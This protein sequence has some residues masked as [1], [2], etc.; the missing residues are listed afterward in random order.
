[1]RPHS[2][3]PRRGGPTRASARKSRDSGVRYKQQGPVNPGAVQSPSSLQDFR[4]NPPHAGKLWPEKI[5]QRFPCRRRDTRDQLIKTRQRSERGFGFMGGLT[6]RLHAR[7]GHGAPLTFLAADKRGL[8]GRARPHRSIF[9]ERRARARIRHRG[10]GLR[11]RHG[12][13]FGIALRFG[14]CRRR[15]RWRIAGGFRRDGHRRD[16]AERF[17]LGGDFD[18]RGCDPRIQPLNQSFFFSPSPAAT[19][20]SGD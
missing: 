4:Q 16:D 13:D 15:G 12:R 1:M 6:Q 7:L 18:R 10:I 11:T 8:V 9:V 19:E 14:L 20:D 17:P 3:R 5:L 2:G